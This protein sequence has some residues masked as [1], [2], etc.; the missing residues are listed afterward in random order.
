MSL[1]EQLLEK[2]LLLGL[3]VLR[4]LCSRGLL[5][6]RSSDGALADVR[7]APDQVHCALD[8]CKHLH[9]LAEKNGN[10]LLHTFS[11][12]KYVWM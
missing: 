3:V 2:T 12:E 7:V 6:G 8:I 11:S 5:R 10:K 1:G 4:A 9:L